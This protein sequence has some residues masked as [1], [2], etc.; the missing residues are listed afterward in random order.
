M[1]KKTKKSLVKIAV[2]FLKLQLAGNILFWGTYLGYA[3]FYEVF[4][5]PGWCSLVIASV[6]SHFAFFIVDRDWVF[7][8]ETGKRKSTGEVVRFIVFM[9]VNFF[10]NL[11]IVLGLEKYFGISPYIGQFVSGLFFTFWTFLGLRFWVFRHARHARHHA[12]TI[13]PK[14]AKEQRH[15]QYRRLETK[16]KTKRTT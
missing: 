4:D 1:K 15:A 12:I 6:F 9:G 2:E 11:G 13:E 8:D 7:S 16:Q 10:I 5:W 3:L 14:S